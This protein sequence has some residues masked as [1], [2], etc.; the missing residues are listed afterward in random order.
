MKKNK[1]FLKSKVFGRRSNPYYNDKA[2]PDPTA[3]YGLKNVIKEDDKM[4]K[5]VRDLVHTI[6]GVVNLTDYE[7]VGRIELRH[8][9]N[10]R[11]FK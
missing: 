9:K 2:Y 4:C 11:I 1:L 6:K 3:Y 8:K 7:I 10:G 5:E